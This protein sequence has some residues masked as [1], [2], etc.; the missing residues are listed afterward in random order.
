MGEGEREREGRRLE[1]ERDWVK[2]AIEI[3]T[4]KRGT[5]GQK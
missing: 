5:L 2:D 4:G 1:R 3:E